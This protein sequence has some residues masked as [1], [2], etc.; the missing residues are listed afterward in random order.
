M[1][2]F[3]YRVKMN[4]IKDVEMIKVITS[5]E[6]NSANTMFNT[7]HPITDT[8]TAIKNLN[9]LYVKNKSLIFLLYHK[10]SK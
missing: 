6:I 9:T 4:K 1:R 7:I 8:T 5:S 10:G 2:S 3:V